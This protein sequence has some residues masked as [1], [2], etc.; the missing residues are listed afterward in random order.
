MIMY[1][2]YKLVKVI[3]KHNPIVNLNFTDTMSPDWDYTFI[4]YCTIMRGRF[5]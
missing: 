2:L 4:N 5:L 1:A 3:I